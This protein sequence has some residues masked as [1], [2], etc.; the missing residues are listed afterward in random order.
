MKELKNK[1]EILNPVGTAW[2]TVIYNL[3]LFLNPKD[4]LLLMTSFIHDY[5]LMLP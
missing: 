2:F 3:Q 5:L 1:V 4:H